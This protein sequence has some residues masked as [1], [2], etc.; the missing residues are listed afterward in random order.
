LLRTNAPPTDF[1][2]TR[3]KAT[4]SETPDH[5]TELDSLI[6]ATTSLL[7]Y[8]TKDRNQAL[9][10]QAIAKKILTP[11]R[12]PSSLRCSL[13]YS[14][15]VGHCVDPR[16]PLLHLRAVPWTLTHVCRE[17]RKV[18]ISYPGEYG[19]PIRLN[20]RLLLS[21]VRYWKS[22]EVRG[23]PRN[24]AFL[25]VEVWVFYRWG[26][27]PIDI[28]SVAPRLRSFYNGH[29]MP[30]S[31]SQPNLVE[32]NQFGILV[33]IEDLTL[34]CGS[35][36]SE[37]PR[38]YLPRV[39]QLGL[40]MSEQSVGTAFITYNHFDLP[41]LAHLDI[42]FISKGQMLPSQVKPFMTWDI[43]L[44][45][46]PYC[47]LPNLQHLTV[48]GCSHI[49]PFLR[50]LSIHP[51]KNVIF[52]KMSALDIECSHFF[53]F[54]DL[55]DMHILVE[56]VQSRLVQGALREFDVWWKTGLSNDDA[57][58]RSRWKLLSELGGGIKISA[59]IK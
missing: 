25:T 48:K 38:I 26:V 6:R 32:F 35:Y 5:I 13:R 9:E 27:E 18:A 22:L 52:P 30:H 19:P 21:S 1:E 54:E 47:R 56:L 4:L 8:L 28:F 17:W 42:L 49:N 40:R 37:L 39:S 53:G 2:R 36:S 15:G 55:L 11:S 43:E 29:W 34:S 33:N 7:D 23:T 14:F 46:F 3:L 44:D 45:L 50:A 12:R 41:S 58:T 57:D 31:C 16:D 59:S 24:L 51:G 10:N 20:F